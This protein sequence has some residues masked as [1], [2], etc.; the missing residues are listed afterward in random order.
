L[1]CRE[2][3]V[4]LRRPLLAA[5][6]VTVST[7]VPRSRPP[8]LAS[9]FSTIAPIFPLVPHI[10]TAITSVLASVE[11]ILDPVGDPT[12]MLPIAPIL[13]AVPDVF[14]PV[15]PVFPAVADILAPIAAVLTTVEAILHT[16]AH[17]PSGTLRLHGVLCCCHTACREQQH[18]RQREQLDIRSHIGAPV[19]S[20]VC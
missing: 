5:V 20:C 3:K 19:I 6:A 17:A 10:L 13:G 15:A 2:G 8:P 4:A 11:T 12:V 14:T 9:V 16:I 7:G 18:G 1:S